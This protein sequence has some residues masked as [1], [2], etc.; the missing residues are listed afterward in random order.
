MKFSP[1][2]LHWVPI[3]THLF[4]LECDPNNCH[5]CDYANAKILKKKNAVGRDWFHVWNERFTIYFELNENFFFV[6]YSIPTLLYPMNE[7][8][9]A[10]KTIAIFLGLMCFM[11][12]LFNLYTSTA[13][14]F[15]ELTFVHFFK[16]WQLI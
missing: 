3:K 7:L 16:P 15:D 10:F 13:S 14:S 8:M 6:L 9:P 5:W 1:F 2:L 11:K 4:K 12:C